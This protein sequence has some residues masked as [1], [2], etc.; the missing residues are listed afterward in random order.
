MTINT[1]RTKIKELY[2]INPNIHVNVSMTRPK[3]A[4]RNSPAIIKAVYEHVFQIQECS[5]EGNRIHTVQYS[6][7]CTKQIEIIE[8]KQ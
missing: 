6:D 5:P 7:I 3:I 2:Q 8:L 4:V 1:V